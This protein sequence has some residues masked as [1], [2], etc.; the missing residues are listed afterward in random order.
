MLVV[1]RYRICDI[2]AVR[3]ELR[4]HIDSVDA[5][6][7]ICANHLTW[8]DSLLIQWALASSIDMLMG[9]GPLTWNL[10]EQT[11]FYARRWMRL[12]C[13]VGQCIPILRG[14]DREAQHAI[15]EKVSG[16]LDVGEVVV[17]F[18]E[19]GRAR[20]GR[21]ELD[22]ITY[23][24]GRIVHAVE[25]CRVL[26][27]YLRGDRQQSSTVLPA[28]GDSFSVCASLLKPTTEHRGLRAARDISRQIG[29]QLIQLEAKYHAGRE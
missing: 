13:F 3:H 14:G 6:I 29:L 9:R 16:L 11:N 12:G 27:I 1:R 2:R 8:I 28:R 25:D 17:L 21:V 18:P 10:P 20:S 26:C 7:L 15:L 19:G 23:G 5:P 4:E 22:A 24:A